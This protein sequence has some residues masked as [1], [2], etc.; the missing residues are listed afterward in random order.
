MRV[1]GRAAATAVRDSRKRPSNGSD[2]SGDSDIAQA[3]WKKSR[4]IEKE[5]MKEK[6]NEWILKRELAEIKAKNEK[7]QANIIEAR[8]DFLVFIVNEHAKYH[9]IHFL[10]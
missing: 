6:E 8:N 1:T 4:S 7:A 9:I 2:S 3:I 10:T 5:S